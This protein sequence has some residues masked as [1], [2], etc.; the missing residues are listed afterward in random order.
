MSKILDIANDLTSLE[1]KFSNDTLTG[2]TFDSGTISDTTLDV[3]VTMASNHP[4]VKSALNASGDAPIYACRAWVN[5]NGAFNDS[6]GNSGTYACSSRT[7]TCSVTSH[8]L[9]AGDSIH[10]VFTRSSGDTTTITD[11]WFVIL[12]VPDSDTFTIQTIASTT[13]QAGTI[14]YDFGDGPIRDSGNV[15]SITDNGTGD[16]TVNFTTAMPNANYQISTSVGPAP[17]S[18]GGAYTLVVKSIAGVT[19]GSVDVRA[20][21]STVNF[22]DLGI[23]CVAIFR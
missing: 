3:D 7:I 13:D 1:S 2:M 17:G 8:G 16:Y 21:R 6:A 20:H 10:A 18:T 15:S 5:F 4:A 22:V 23:C 19:T 9:S 14:S 11:D 12:T